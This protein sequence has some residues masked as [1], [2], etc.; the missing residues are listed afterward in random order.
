[1]WTQTSGSTFT[2]ADMEIREDWSDD[3]NCYAW[4]LWYRNEYYG[5]Y[6]INENEAM[7]RCEFIR[8]EQTTLHGG[9]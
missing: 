3:H 6:P 1:M 7:R 2:S 9:L 8:D 4:Q 5:A